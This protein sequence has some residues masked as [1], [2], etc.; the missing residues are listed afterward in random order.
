MLGHV[1]K[2]LNMVTIVTKCHDLVP[3]DNGNCTPRCQG[4]VGD[5][6]Y[7][8][9]YSGYDL[10]GSNNVTCTHKG[11]WTLPAPICKSKNIISYSS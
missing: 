11:E 7:F 4:T 10:V 6:I 5:S 9:C 2:Y 3:P 1:V 8:T